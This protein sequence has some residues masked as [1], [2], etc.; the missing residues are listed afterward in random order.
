M[1]RNKRESFEENREELAVQPESLAEEK[2]ELGE[3]QAE[4]K[5]EVAQEIEQ[6]KEVIESQLEEVKDEISPEERKKIIEEYQEKYLPEHLKEKPG[7]LFSVAKKLSSL[8]FKHKTEGRENVPDGP[9]LIVSNHFG[10]EG[11]MLAQEFQD[12]D[13]H[14]SLGKKIWWERSGILKWVF[15]KA[16][17]LPVQESLS[18]LSKEEKEEALEKQD[19]HGKKVFREIIDNEEE[20]KLAIDKEFIRGAVAALSRGDAVSIFPEGLW[21]NPNGSVTKAREK[22]EMKQGYG[23]MELIAREFK[24][25]TGQELNI[26]PVAVDEDRTSKK[27]PVMRMGKPVTLSENDSEN[28]DTDWVMAQ[29][30][31]MLPEEQRGYYKE[32]KKRESI[33]KI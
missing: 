8:V 17:M 16:R 19:A 32:A 29:V 14:V 15:Q 22:Q 2:M 25:V 7:T 12:R 9:L 31:Q 10:D 6:L 33:D 3:Q 30:A 5:E 28:S 18:N 24:K 26:L 20:G 21:L 13:V 11:I 27:R 4:N 23:G 1:S